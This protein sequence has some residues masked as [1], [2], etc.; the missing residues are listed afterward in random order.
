[1]NTTTGIMAPSDNDTNTEIDIT[2]VDIDIT[3][4][5]DD[6]SGD[7]STCDSCPGPVV[8]YVVKANDTLTT[9]AN[10]YQSGIC[11]IAKLNSIAD[12]NYILSG[13]TLKVPTMVCEP[14]NTSC[15]AKA[16]TAVCVTDKP[17]T[18][19][20]SKGETFY[21]IA[22]KLGLDYHFLMAANPNVEPESLD[23]GQVINVPICPSKN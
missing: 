22:Q 2:I 10:K 19:T 9:I 21:T 20:V 5:D 11:Q 16:G 7:N 15:M 12:P 18:W 4:E 3:I 23:A 14:D 6:N 17:A 1:M 13:A 8:D